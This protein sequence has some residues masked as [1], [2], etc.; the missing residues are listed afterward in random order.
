[1]FF[2]FFKQKTAYEMLRS[3]VG[4][5]MC[6]RDSYMN[7]SV[8]ID[9]LPKPFDRFQEQLHGMVGAYAYGGA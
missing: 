8:E 2:F 6:I 5:E 3:L 7:V 4:S 1:M 9:L